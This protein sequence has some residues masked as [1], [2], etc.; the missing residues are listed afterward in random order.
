[1]VRLELADSLL[2]FSFLNSCGPTSSAE[3]GVVAAPQ[4]EKSMDE[5]IRVSL[6]LGI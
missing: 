5:A 2:F 3:D 1:M 4:E 6:L